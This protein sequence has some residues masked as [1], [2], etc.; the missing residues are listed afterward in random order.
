MNTRNH[1]P[2][3]HSASMVCPRLIFIYILTIMPVK[4]WITPRISAPIS[5]GTASSRGENRAGRAKVLAGLKS[6]MS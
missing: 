5:T 2:S 6:L 1:A 4:T 3:P